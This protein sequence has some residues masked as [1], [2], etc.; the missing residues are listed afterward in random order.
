MRTTSWWAPR[1]ASHNGRSARV[2][3]KYG[4]PTVGS[5]PCERIPIRP[6]PQVDVLPI[7]QTRALDSTVVQREAQWFDEMKGRASGQAGAAGV[8]GV[9]MDLRVDEDNVHSRL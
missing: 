1:G 5:V 9:P 4:S 7:V 3:K 6:H 8:A 2:E